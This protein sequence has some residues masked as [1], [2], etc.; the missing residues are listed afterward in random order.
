[1]AKRD[2]I[3]RN[4]GILT[5]DIQSHPICL[6]SYYS[7][8]MSREGFV[9]KKPAAGPQINFRCLLGLLA[10]SSLVETHK[11]LYINPRSKA[12]EKLQYIIYPADG[13]NVK[14]T[15]DTERF[16]QELIGNNEINVAKSP[17]L[18]VLAWGLKL[19]SS[20]FDR[21]AA[22]EEGI[23]RILEDNVVASED[24]PSNI[25]H[26]KRTHRKRTHRKLA[27][28]ASSTLTSGILT[29][30]ESKIISQADADDDLKVLAEAS[31]YPLNNVKSYVYDEKAGEGIYI[32]VLDKGFNPDNSDFINMEHPPEE[33]DW[34]L[35]PS[36]YPVNSKLSKYAAIDGS[37]HGNCIASKAAG[38]KSGVAKK[39]RLVPVVSKDSSDFSLLASNVMALNHIWEHKRQGR[40]VVLFAAGKIVQDLLEDDTTG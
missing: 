23:D 30:H 34:L 25:T 12:T 20:Q 16:L 4:N 13:F 14:Q 11:A 18:G 37:G 39:A 17:L 9:L 10:V 28:D 2:I 38:A 40:A 6:H 26:R 24:V 3:F 32:Y 31:P 8:I 21:V 36:S 22:H 33:R 1:M 35:V 29:G 7:E 5:F 27:R 19:D 15:N